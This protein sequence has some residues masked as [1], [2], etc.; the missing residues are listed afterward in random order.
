MAPQ[1]VLAPKQ[2]SAGHPGARPVLCG[3]GRGDMEH[4]GG[5]ISDTHA[6]VSHGL[7]AGGPRARRGQ[8][9]S[10][11]ASLLGSHMVPSSL[12]P[13]GRPRIC[14]SWSLL[15]KTP[16]RLDGGPHGWPHFSLIT[17]LKT[18]SPNPVPFRGP[19]G[20]KSNLGNVSRPRSACHTS[21]RPVGA[22]VSPG[23]KAPCCRSARA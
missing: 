7:D 20:E 2:L 3:S 13:H 10:P 5:S 15:I 17:S 23:V 9:G 16:V 21:H 8:V 18:L 6:C 11:A 14:L 22:D 4:G 1:A 19:G 12:C